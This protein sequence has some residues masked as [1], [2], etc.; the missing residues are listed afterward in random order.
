MSGSS[1]AQYTHHSIQDQL[2]SLLAKYVRPDIVSCLKSAKYFA[3][4]CDEAKDDGKEEQL[5]ICLCFVECGL[6]HGDLYNF[7]N[8]DGLGSRLVMAVLKEQLDGMGVDSP[9]NLIAQSYDGA[10]VMFGR[11]GGRQALMRE[12]ICPLA[13]YVHCWAHRLNLVVVSCVY[14]LDKAARFFGNM[15]TLYKFFSASV[16]LMTISTLH[17]RTYERIQRKEEH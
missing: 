10:S 17:E 16:C 12:S 13:I 6:L 5:S 9:S 3:I 7:V 15:Q 11:M 8:I 2:L 4:M 14:S 1:H